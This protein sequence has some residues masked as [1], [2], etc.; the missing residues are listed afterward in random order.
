MTRIQAY[1]AERVKKLTISNSTLIVGHLRKTRTTPPRK[2]TVSRSL[3]FCAKKSNIFCGPM[4]RKCPPGKRTCAAKSLGLV[5][6]KMAQAN[7]L[8]RVGK[9]CVR[10]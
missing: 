7:D 6:S 9:V 4:T 10:F 3:F 8:E 1:A 5:S 2:Q